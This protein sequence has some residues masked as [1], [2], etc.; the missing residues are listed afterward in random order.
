MFNQK[1]KVFSVI[2]H[3]CV[4]NR[5]TTETV[6]NIKVS[7]MLEIICEEVSIRVDNCTVDWTAEVL[8]VILFEHD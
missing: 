4:V 5:P 7:D 8:C 6:S 2:N 3:S 1:F